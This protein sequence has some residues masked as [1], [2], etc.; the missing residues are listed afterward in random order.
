[1]SPI[2][3]LITAVSASTALMRLKDVS[4]SEGMA[5]LPISILSNQPIEIDSEGGLTLLSLGIIVGARGPDRLELPRFNYKTKIRRSLIPHRTLT[6]WPV[7]WFVL[8]FAS[9]L[10]FAIA[11]DALLR[12]ITSV[13]IGFCASSWLHLAMDIL[14]PAGI[15][16]RTP[17]GKRTS[18]NL[19]KTS[20]LGE[21]LCI[22]VFVFLTQ[23]LASLHFIFFM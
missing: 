11:Q 19:Y 3:H 5:S 6:H 9:C 22:L 1:M 7:F 8:T 13:G 16:L 20:S 21:W 4:W 2:G 12:A 17:F 15:P 10:F 23:S 18:L 14:T